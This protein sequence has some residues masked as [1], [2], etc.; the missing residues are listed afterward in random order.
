MLAESDIEQIEQD[1]KNGVRGEAMA[2]W[3]EKLLRDREE[4]IL[5]DREVAVQLLADAPTHP[6]TPHAQA[7][8]KRSQRS[9]SSRASDARAQREES[10]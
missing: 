2:V 4:R 7:P 5:H 6:P 8:E 1:L 3:V 10:P 9:H